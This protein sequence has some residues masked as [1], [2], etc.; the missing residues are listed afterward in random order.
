MRKKH[1]TFDGTSLWWGDGHLLCFMI[2]K[3]FYLFDLRWSIQQI[4]LFPF[5]RLCTSTFIQASIFPGHRHHK[6]WKNAAK[7]PVSR[8]NGLRSWDKTSQDE[9]FPV[10]WLAERAYHSAPWSMAIDRSPLRFWVWENLL[11]V[12]F[13]EDLGPEISLHDQFHH[14]HYGL[15]SYG[16]CLHLPIHLRI[17]GIAFFFSLCH[18]RQKA[19]DSE[20][21]TVF[22]ASYKDGVSDV[23]L[24]PLED[25]AILVQVGQKDSERCSW[26]G[27]SHC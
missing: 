4:S 15:E 23:P 2:A 3:N 27:L 13:P 5:S 8:W 20:F 16:L 1:E 24:R 22:S 17:V 7:H 9:V 26:D 6:R 18:Y 14:C 11:N 12:P 19:K 10:E 25:D 21:S